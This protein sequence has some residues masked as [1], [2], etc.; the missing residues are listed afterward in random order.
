MLDA[1]WLPGCHME[2]VKLNP[3][4]CQAGW[5][6]RDT[7]YGSLLHRA[8]SITL[9]RAPID[10]WA[11]TARP[12]ASPRGAAGVGA[13]VRRVVDC[14][15]ELWW[16]D[17]DALPADEGPLASETS[18]SSREGTSCWL[19]RRMRPIIPHHHPAT[20]ACTIEVRHLVLT[21]FLSERLMLKPYRE[22]A[23]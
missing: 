16:Q 13:C 22:G 17:E 10:G 5:H 14:A 23:Q 2:R 1:T 4:Q 19:R 9:S 3:L 18:S 20:A 8:R 21:K 6:T 7:K 11:A 15:E 12:I